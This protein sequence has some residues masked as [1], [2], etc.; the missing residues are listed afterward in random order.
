MAKTEE[1]EEVN[2]GRI[3]EAEYDESLQQLLV[4][5][6]FNHKNIT[7]LTSSPLT[8]YTTGVNNVLDFIAHIRLVFKNDLKESCIFKLSSGRRDGKCFLF[9]TNLSSNEIRRR[10][11]LKAFL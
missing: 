2:T 1:E 11:E 3:S 4:A 8:R 10:L 9:H 7:N 5:N 6:G